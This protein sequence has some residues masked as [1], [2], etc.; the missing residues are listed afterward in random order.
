MEEESWEPSHV[1][2]LIPT[3]SLA[4]TEKVTV[5]VWDEVDK[6][7]LELDAVISPTVGFWSSV[8]DILIVTLSV[9]VLPAASATVNVKLSVDEPKL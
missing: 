7:I 2:L 6:S 1:T 3:L 4:T 8:L 5:S 9:D